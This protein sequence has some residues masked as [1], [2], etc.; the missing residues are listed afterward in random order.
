MENWLGK[1]W[2]SI[3]IAVAGILATY[4][5]F[6]SSKKNSDQTDA[7][8]DLGREN[9][10]LAREIQKLE[11]LN[12]QV[13]NEVQTMSRENNKLSQIN[14]ELSRRSNQLI[15]EVRDLTVQSKA[16][17]DR[18]ETRG[19][20]EAEVN[21][22]TGEFIDLGNY[23]DEET[24]RVA[25]GG[26]TTGNSVENWNAGAKG[27]F[28][29]NTDLFDIRFVDKKLMLTL[30]VYDD[31][32]NVVAEIENSKWRPNPNFSGK[33]NYDDRGFE[34]INNQGVVA[35]S[36]DIVDKKLIVFQGLFPLNNTVML[37]AGMGRTIQVP[38]HLKGQQI[39]GLEGKMVDYHTA[40]QQAI[41]NVR[42]RQL[43]EYTGSDWLHKRK[44]Y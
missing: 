4:G 16:L 12:S 19:Q 35:V 9:N 15:D 6:I 2:P 44:Q 27:I 36:V 40:L 13:T 1:Y 38:L 3:L 21:V 32:G 14:I 28:M 11:Q 26:I 43:F 5:T 25:V 31:V 42:M 18:I 41:K 24:V 37:V 23:E 30:N 34:V 29:G 10:K 20:Y 8:E 33:F 39:M 7:I 17:I 22:K